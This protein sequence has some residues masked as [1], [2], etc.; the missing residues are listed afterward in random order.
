VGTTFV[1]AGQKFAVFQAGIDVGKR[2]PARTT[3]EFTSEP[4]WRAGAMLT[5]LRVLDTSLTQGDKPDAQVRV[6]NDAVDQSFSN[7][8]A[9]IILYDK[10]NN[11]VS[12]S[13]T[14]IDSIGPT[15]TQTLYFTWP[16]A[17][18]TDVVRT[19][20]LFSLNPSR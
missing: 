17:F 10:D 11:R 6:K 1:P 2:T 7:V 8:S 12:F 13:R 14:S 18:S 16:K 20:V 5:K 19:E 3:F 15:E 9:F 4:N